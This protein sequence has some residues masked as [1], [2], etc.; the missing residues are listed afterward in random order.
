MPVILRL[1]ELQ[2]RYVRLFE[3]M[4]AFRYNNITIQY[5]VDGLYNH[6][7][8]ESAYLNVVR[9]HPLLRASI[10][11]GNDETFKVLDC[12][13]EPIDT[14]YVS[15]EGL[16]EAS[17]R[18]AD[19]LNN[20]LFDLG[21][22]PLLRFGVVVAEKS[23][24]NLVLCV[25]H[26]VSDGLSIRIIL[27]DLFDE[28]RV[29]L[30]AARRGAEYFAEC[31]AR[32]I[33]LHEQMIDRQRELIKCA[34]ADGRLFWWRAMLEPVVEGERGSEF[35]RPKR[36][37]R[38]IPQST[39]QLLRQECKDAGVREASFLATT[40][41]LATGVTGEKAVFKRVILR[42]GKD[43]DKLVGNAIDLQFVRFQVEEDPSQCAR[44]MEEFVAEAVARD[45]PAWWIVKNLYPDLY[46]QRSAG[47]A[48]E[49]NIFVPA[50]HIVVEGPGIKVAK[51]AE[52]ELTI[53]PQYN[54]SF[55]IQPMS[56]GESKAALI[57]N[58]AAIEPDTAESIMT[59]FQVGLTNMR[60]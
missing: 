24:W 12:D 42:R 31:N 10:Q 9:K 3:R 50:S 21:S 60:N 22:P 5:A 48:I 56:D 27:A 1:S 4:H 19:K 28:Y 33:A 25:H 43:M 41:V 44:R 46:L 47:V 54:L 51:A 11:L 30:S 37:D 38:R 45:A 55:V 26:L 59:R 16:G 2:Q 17:T 39:M 34:E 53:W 13:P 49:V 6:A 58:P 29:A 8:F 14:I 57:Y 52:Q 20:T 7:A 40:A 32:S 36:L 15:A 23:R 35:S 18:L